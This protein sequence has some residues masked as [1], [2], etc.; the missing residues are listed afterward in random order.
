MASSVL[1]LPHLPIPDLNHPIIPHL[2]KLGDAER[3][4]KKIPIYKNP[5]GINTPSQ[6]SGG[7]SP[8]D[9]TGGAGKIISSVPDFLEAITK[10]ALWI[11]VG[12][13]VV[14]VLLLAIGFTE[15]FPKGTIAKAV[16]MV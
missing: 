9:I 1:H 6:D 15:M 5:D 8:D 10:P 3:N 16:K 4:L 12:E 13:F 14:G 2:P 11:R 7:P